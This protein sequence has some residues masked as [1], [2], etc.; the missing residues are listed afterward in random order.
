MGQDDLEPAIQAV[1]A[2]FQRREVDYEVGSMST[3][4]W[5]EDANVFAAL[6]EA[7]KD[8]TECGSTVMVITLSNA[9]P[10]PN[11]RTDD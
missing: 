2:A 7:F 8:A 4:A 1:W 3:I 10:V 11:R 6:Q 5:G 9:C